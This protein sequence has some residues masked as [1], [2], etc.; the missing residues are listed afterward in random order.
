M[1]NRLDRNSTSISQNKQ[2]YQQAS[3]VYVGTFD[4]SIPASEKPMDNDNDPL[5][6]ACAQSDLPSCHPKDWPQAP[7][8]LRPSPGSGTRVKGVRL[9]DSH[10]YMWEPGSHLSWQEALANEW[11][12]PF[13]ARPNYACCEKCAILPIN[14][15]NEEIGKALVI[16]FESDLFQGSLMLRLRFAEGTT[17]EPYDDNKGYFR[18]MNRRYQAVI[19]GRFKKNIPLTELVTGFQF[20]RPCG[21]LPA[22]WVLRGGMKVIS[23]FAPQLDAKL[24]GDRPHCLTP[25]GST[26]QSVSV[27]TQEWDLLDGIREEPVLPDRTLLGTASLAAAS[28]HRARHRKKAFDKLVV[29]KSKEPR[30]DPSKI[31]TFEF[32]QHLFNFQ[33]FS[34]ELGSMLGSVHL[35]ETLDG[36]PLQIMAAHGK[37]PLFSFDVWHECLW[38]KAQKRCS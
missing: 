33:D 9:S 35:E 17:P 10:E 37:Q 6:C 19:R 31:Y 29:H 30:T 20:N 22:K 13:E 26:P 4:P 2:R 38:E 16:D 32:L 21:K 27:E 12:R 11:D 15:G 36:Q 18:G 23:F 28:V 3:L 5:P 14:S 34:I 25:L 7:L 8:L 24:E 1:Q